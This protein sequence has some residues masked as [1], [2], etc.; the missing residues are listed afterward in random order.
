MAEILAVEG[1]SFFIEPGKEKSRIIFPL[2]EA[3]DLRMT[4]MPE[5]S[6]QTKRLIPVDLEAKAEPFLIEIPPRQN[7][8]T[9]F[10]L[11]KGE[12]MG[13]LLS[14]K[15]V[16]KMGSGEHELLPGDLIPLTSEIPNAWSNLGPDPAKLLWLLVK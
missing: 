9:H 15:L 6:I 4:G 14:G 12:E 16:M 11:H 13:Y 5:F 10:F 8:S 7:L 1:S 3:T 2:R